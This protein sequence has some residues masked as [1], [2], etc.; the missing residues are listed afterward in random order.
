MSDFQEAMAR[1]LLA[2][3]DDAP[4]ALGHL[5]AQPGFT[6][7][8]N[9]VLKGCVEAL[10]ANFPTVARLVG[11]EWFRDAA[12]AY[13]RA[14]PP[15]DGRLLAYGDE[16]FGAFVQA[17]PTA[18]GLPYLAGVATLD[19]LWRA[20]HAAGDAPVLPAAALAG[21][22]AQALASHALLPHPAAR[23]AW[24]DGMPVAS[25]WARERTPSPQPGDVPWRGE[26]LLLT[27]SGGAVDW[28]ALP[29]AG[30]AL[31][32]A[33]AQGAS[34][35]DAAAQALACDPTTDLGP[36]LARLLESGAFTLS[37]P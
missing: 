35:G 20:C 28:I 18:A 16:G 2:P 19:A 5:L 32:D 12:L 9:T 7:I 4:H 37:P 21:L 1:A 24:F 33:C 3:G 26:G 13:V 31:M 15:R 6:V 14:H 17:V 8:R 30:C 23:W 29:Q 36:V 11:S 27:R 25:L 22:D 10:E 34:L